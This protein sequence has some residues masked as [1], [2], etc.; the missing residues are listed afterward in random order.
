LVNILY[1]IQYLGHGGTE[2]QL[3]Q[4]I[5]GLEGSRFQPHLCTLMPSGGYFDELAVPK[6]C[7]Q[8]RS[9]RNHTLLTRIARLSVFIRRHRI[10]IVQT[11]FQDPFLLAAIIKLW[12]EYKLIGSFR[13]LGFWRSAGAICKMRMAYPFFDGFVANSE[14]VKD[15]FVR[16][17]R[18]HPNQIEV[19][20]NGID[21]NE[22][23]PVCTGGLPLVGIVAN[24]NRGVK[25]V[26]D[27]IQ[28][29]ALVHRNRPETRFMIVGDGPQRPELEKLCRSLDLEGVT[30]FSGQLAA[31]LDLVRGFGVGV[32]TSESE[33][34]CN[35][36]M[37]YMACGVPVVATAAGGNPELVN[38]GQNG[39]LVP[40][41]DIKQMAEKIE[42]LLREDKL[43]NRM[44]EANRQKIVRDFKLSRMI[45]R[46]ESFYDRI[47]R[48]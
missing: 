23:K 9:F 32:I 4:L 1:I 20:Y 15:F 18:L 12:R 24:C 3:V 48:S 13:D 33:G 21:I 29:A 22:S 10:Q 17:D 6:I 41:G 7:L 8:F 45:D 47:L 43:R 30:T 46:Y 26:Q 31:P 14:A 40:V 39:F 42:L 11:Y 36:I 37:E 35:A 2:K 38:D 25:R 19:I 28:A 27:F 44:R 16:A 5:R 34:F